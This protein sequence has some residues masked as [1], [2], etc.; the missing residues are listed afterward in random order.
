[1]ALLPQQGPYSLARVQVELVEAVADPMNNPDLETLR[2]QI[3]S[4][5]G[6]PLLQALASGRAQRVVLEYLEPLSL[7]VTIQPCR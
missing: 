5:R 2:R 4:A 7:A 3:P 1:L 6:L